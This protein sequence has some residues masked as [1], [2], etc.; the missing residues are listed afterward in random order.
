MTHTE[1]CASTVTTS[2]P[3]IA[4]QV[5]S[6]VISTCQ[7]NTVLLGYSKIGHE[8]SYVWFHGYVRVC[9]CSNS[10]FLSVGL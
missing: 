8:Y 4:D 1:I 10:Y 5:S 9:I 6:R 2:I 3:A 7:S